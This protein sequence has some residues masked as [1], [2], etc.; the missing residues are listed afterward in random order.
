MTAKIIRFGPPASRQQEPPEPSE[1]YDFWVEILDGLSPR[2]RQATIRRASECRVID[3]QDTKI[4]S[5]M[6]LDRDSSILSEM[7]PEREGTW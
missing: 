6:W 7:W 5:E 1:P 4:L 2:E 3:A